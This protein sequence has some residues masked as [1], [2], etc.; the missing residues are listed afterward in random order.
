MSYYFFS[1]KSTPK[2]HRALFTRLLISCNTG[3]HNP[4]A[5]NCHCHSIQVSHV[6]QNAMITSNNCQQKTLNV[7]FCRSSFMFYYLIDK[8]FSLEISDFIRL[9][10]TEIS[11]NVVWIPIISTVDWNSSSLEIL[12]F[13]LLHV[14]PNQK[15]NITIFHIVQGWL[16]RSFIELNLWC[17]L[18]IIY[19]DFIFWLKNIKR[20]I[21][22][23]YTL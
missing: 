10:S 11:F 3:I 21:S 22:K 5:T 13:K 14:T 23:W 9:R 12:K 1:G 7:L 15:M 19:S 18:Q 20:D 17:K 6:I 4:K 2:S 8:E 16:S